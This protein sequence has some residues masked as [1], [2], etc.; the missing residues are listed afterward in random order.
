MAISEGGG[1]E[2]ALYLADIRL[3]EKK[4]KG[5]A[6]GRGRCS[7]GGAA[8]PRGPYGKG[9]SERSGGTQNPRRPEREIVP[10]KEKKENLY[11]GKT[12]KS[13]MEGRKN[14]TTS[15]LGFQKS[16][17]KQQSEREDGGKKIVVGKRKKSPFGQ[18]PPKEKGTEEGKRKLVGR[19]GDVRQARDIF[20]VQAY[21]SGRP[22]NTTREDNLPAKEGKKGLSNNVRRGSN[23]ELARRKKYDRREEARQGRY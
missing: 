20:A 3:E 12:E 14:L 23:V 18:S 16:K 13:R 10:G 1:K 15:P 5:D 22:F 17:E 9:E 6:S 2:S 21:S 4:E 19:T 11:F 7:C 8:I